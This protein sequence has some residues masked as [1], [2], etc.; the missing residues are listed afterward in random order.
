M[1]YFLGFVR[2]QLSTSVTI[3]LVFGPKVSNS[4]KVL[5]FMQSFCEIDYNFNFSNFLF[6]TCELM[7]HLPPFQGFFTKL[8]V[9][10][11]FN[12]ISFHSQI[13]YTVFFS[14]FSVLQFLRLFRGTANELDERIRARGHAASMIEVPLEREA[15]QK[16]VYVEN[17]ELKV[18][19][20][21][22]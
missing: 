21:V 8:I 20:I 16:D 6:L 9:S 1:K 17:E 13:D 5:F 3:V 18:R 12:C 11:F 7:D 15:S 4:M 19:L 10:I 2:T 14:L 22:N